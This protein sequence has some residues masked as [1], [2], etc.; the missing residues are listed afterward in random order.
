MMNKQITKWVIM[1]GLAAGAVGVGVGAGTASAADQGAG[2]DMQ[3]TT[4]ANGQTRSQ[5][6]HATAVITAIDHSARTVTLKGD[7]GQLNTIDVP[8]DVKAFDKL[9][10][11]DKVDIDYYQSL[12]VSMLPPGSKLTTTEKKGRMVDMG[13]GVTGKEITTSA[14]VVAVDPAANTVTF[15]GQ[16][17]RVTTI[18]VYDPQ[19][20]Q[21]LPSLKPG[22]VVQ[23]SYTEAVAAAIRP[24][25][26]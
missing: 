12:A 17:G 15:K 13:G 18:N 8:S 21:K 19:L 4:T 24:A 14:E 10:V 22:Q 16:H 20:Q 7:D 26:K 11:G 23:F 3:K 25:S 1:A 9:K 5:L 6:I 2:V